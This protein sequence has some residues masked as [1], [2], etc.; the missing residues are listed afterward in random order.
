[1][2]VPKR[3]PARSAKSA[4]PQTVGTVRQLL[5]RRDKLQSA[6]MVE[7][8]LP[9]SLVTDA[10]REFGIP[11]ERLIDVIGLSKSTVIRKEAAGERFDIATGDVFKEA[12]AI[13][14][15][16][17]DMLGGDSEAL[18][19]WLDRPIPALGRAPIALLRT[20]DGRELV[21]G[22]LDRIDSG[23]YA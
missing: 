15:R 10:A 21:S 4:R 14:G 22:I 8:G 23:A 11:K 18:K 16:A 9:V 12:A 2:R 1:M 6:M 20:R 13:I 7:A 17:L 19:A 5:D 3:L